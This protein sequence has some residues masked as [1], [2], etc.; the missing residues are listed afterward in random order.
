MDISYCLV[1]IFGNEQADSFEK[2]KCCIITPFD[3]VITPEDLKLLLFGGIT[4]NQNDQWLRH[5]QLIAV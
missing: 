1:G 4:N 3:D 2:K 5:L